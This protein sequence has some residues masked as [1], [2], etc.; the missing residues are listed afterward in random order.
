MFQIFLKFD[1]KYPKNNTQL[2]LALD[3]MP[4]DYPLFRDKFI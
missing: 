3:L 2:K 4:V 1:N